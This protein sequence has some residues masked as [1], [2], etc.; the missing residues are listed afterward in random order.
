M[1]CFFVSLVCSANSYPVLPWE[2]NN[3]GEH[4]GLVKQSS[5]DPRYVSCSA[6]EA[7]KVWGGSPHDDRTEQRLRESCPRCG[8]MLSFTQ[9]LN[10]TM[11][12]DTAIWGVVEGP[13]LFRR[14]G[15]VYLLMSHS[16]F[17]SAFYSVMWAAAPTVEELD[18]NNQKRMVG[19]FLI[20]SKDQNFGHGTAVLGPG[21]FNF[22]RC[23]RAGCCCFL[24]SLMCFCAFVLHAVPF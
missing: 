1:L 15:L 16:C 9:G 11:M 2:Q 8:E 12:R 17:N 7:T 18:L 21:Q 14:A 6:A 5:A 19:R 4:V 24:S 22:L 20:P 13:M 23:W 3:L 10:G